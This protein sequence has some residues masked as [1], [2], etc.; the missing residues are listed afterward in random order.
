[1]K[2]YTVY[3]KYKVNEVQGLFMF[4]LSGQECS[5][6]SFLVYSLFRC[7][8]LVMLHSPKNRYG[9]QEAATNNSR[10]TVK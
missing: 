10:V 2:V 1:M 8:C 9:C 7:C 5:P 4:N 6:V 3:L